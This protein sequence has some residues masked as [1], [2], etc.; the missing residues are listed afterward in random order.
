MRL[1]SDRGFKGL[2]R[3]MTMGIA[4]A[5]MIAGA[6][7]SDDD[8]VT[9][10]TPE[11]PRK[12]IAGVMQELIDAYEAR[13]IA[14]Y[15]ALFDDSSF[16]FVFDPTDVQGDPDIPPN[17][18]WNEERNATTNMFGAN[19]V[20]RIQLDY[21]VG[22][23]VLADTLDEGIRPFPEG[24]MKAIVTNVELSVDTRDPAGGENII[25]KVAGDQAIFF[26]WQD[27]QEIVDGVPVWKIIEWRDKRIGPAPFVELNSWGGV[28]S[29]Y[30]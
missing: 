28:K 6:G 1:R 12:T 22:T 16:V 23:P 15:A 30:S 5:M 10:P 21:V 26:L 24:T 17:W 25:Y 9:P 27:P 8:K 19:L 14:R 11:D 13:D 3:R 4:A 18:D 2:G 29:L 20:Q 7:C